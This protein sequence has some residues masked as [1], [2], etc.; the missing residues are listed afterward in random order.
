MKCICFIA[1]LTCWSFFCCGQNKYLVQ[2]TNKNENSFSLDNPTAFLSQRAIDRRNKSNISIDSLDLPI[3][4]KYI[5]SIQ[6]AGNVSILNKSK[7][8][9]QIVIQTNDI[10]ALTKIASFS[11]VRSYKNIASKIST[12]NANNKFET[13]I[14]HSNVPS[15]FSKSQTVNS[16]NYGNA[17]AQI[18]IH[19][20]DFLHN[21]F[22]RGEDMQIAILDAGFYNYNLLPTFDSVQ[23]NNQILG[24]WDFVDN[25]SS[26]SED[27]LH[28]MECFSI[29]AANLPGIFVGAAPKSSYYLYRTEDVNSEYPIEEHNMA[30][31]A[32]M[33]DSAGA[34]ICSISLGYNT[35]DNS[36]FDYTYSDMNGHTTMSAK[37]LN[38]AHQKGMLMVTAAGNEGNNSWHY[39]STPGDA[40]HAL[41]IAAVDSNK[42]VGFFSSYGPN[43][44][45]QIKPTIASL[46]V[47][48]VIADPNTGLPINGNGTSYACPN[49]AGLSACLW[50]AFPEAN[51][52]DIFEALQKNTD[53]PTRPDYRTGYGIPDLKKTFVYLQKKFSSNPTS[54]SDCKS[55]IHLFVKTDSSMQ[56]EVE[57]KTNSDNAYSKIATL[58]NQSNY[59]LHEFSFVDD[60]SLL[61]SVSTA[62]YRYKVVIASDT[63]YYIDS[64]LITI[65]ISCSNTNSCETNYWNGN[66]N[67]CWEN[68]E[69]WSCHSIPNATTIV[70]IE[71]GKNFYPEVSSMASCK[72]ILLYKDAIIKINTGFLLNIAGH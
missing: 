40:D 68:P 18:K 57:R 35:F 58:K 25:E 14:P 24:T 19:K 32:E 59:G 17:G 45:G 70:Y 20:G 31:A 55:F 62:S 26:V 30:A 53:H 1:C 12:H 49:I 11:F 33:A 16:L 43:S 39:I 36:I 37:A 29:M 67:V 5:D 4:Q 22:F 7:W 42:L 48:A 38:I 64:N 3:T 66:I 63:S 50:Q 54:F 2:F 34:D 9:N 28:G 15:L 13:S 8:L 56:I 60:L 44:S 41:S 65:P 27:Y 23:L 6:S 61:S 71:S 10:V 47:R 72:K 52:N 51:N 46:G 69:N 21:H